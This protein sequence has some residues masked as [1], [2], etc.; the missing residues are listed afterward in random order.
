MKIS[1]G[2]FS[3]KVLNFIIYFFLGTV[4]KAVVTFIIL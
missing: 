2:F 3:Q 1:E 4:R